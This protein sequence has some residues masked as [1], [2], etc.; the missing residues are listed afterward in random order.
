MVFTEGEILVATP[1]LGVKHCF[2]FS[3]CETKVFS[4]NDV[5]VVI[6]YITFGSVLV[7]QRCK[8]KVCTE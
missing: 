5:K 6:I 3:Y 1:Y 8:V 4:H 2:V 7:M